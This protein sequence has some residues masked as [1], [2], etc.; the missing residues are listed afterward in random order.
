MVFLR[1]RPDQHAMD[2]NHTR[3]VEKRAAIFAVRNGL[4]SNSEM[5]RNT[6]DRESKITYTPFTY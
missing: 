6:Q 3:L 1:T 5:R 4:F 2:Q